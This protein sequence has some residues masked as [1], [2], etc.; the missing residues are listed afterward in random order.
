MVQ[1]RNNMLSSE[2]AFKD[3]FQTLY[4]SNTLYKSKILTITHA[5]EHNVA[6]CFHL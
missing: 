1:G 3:R 4:N 2:I 6:M 5:A